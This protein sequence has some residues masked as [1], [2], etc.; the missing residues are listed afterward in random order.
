MTVTI[1]VTN[2]DVGIIASGRLTCVN[3]ETLLS[4]GNS[5]PAIIAAPTSAAQRAETR[6]HVPEAGC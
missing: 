2:G 1:M 5:P 6:S 3:V 4:V